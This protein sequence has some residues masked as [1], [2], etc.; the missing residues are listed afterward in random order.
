MYSTRAVIAAS[1]LMTAACGSASAQN[2]A[3][4]VIPAALMASADAWNKADLPGHIGLYTDN[5]TFMGA[6]GPIQG[7]ERVGESLARSFWRDGKP[8]QTLSFDRIDV[9]PLGDR[10]ALSTGHFVLSGGGEA[11]RSGWFS[12]TWEK[13]GGGWRI[14]HDHSS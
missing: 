11:E 5:A 13:S 8:K 14:I 12:L 10:H 7:R 6:N 3:T 4:T 9:R 2:D 1:V